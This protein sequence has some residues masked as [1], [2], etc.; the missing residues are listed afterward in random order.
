MSCDQI[1][2]HFKESFLPKIK[3]QLLKID[4]TDTAKVNAGILVLLF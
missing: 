3:S 1:L 2:E 4:D